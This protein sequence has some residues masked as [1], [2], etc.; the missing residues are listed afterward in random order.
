MIALIYVDSE[1]RSENVWTDWIYCRNG[2]S[3]LVSVVGGVAEGRTGV[4]EVV[5]CQL[6]DCQ[7]SRQVS[8]PPLWARGCHTKCWMLKRPSSGHTAGG[9]TS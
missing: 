1:V 3:H 6:C 7:K 9:D 5:C 8:N 2:W 4:K